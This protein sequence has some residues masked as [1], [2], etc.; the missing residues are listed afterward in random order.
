MKEK[1]AI[2]VDAGYITI[3]LHKVLGRRVDANTIH[4]YCNG[5]LNL[6]PL[7]GC[8]LFRIYYYDCP[9]IDDEFTDPNGKV[10]NFSKS[11]GTHYREKVR[12][13]LRQLSNV[14]IRTGELTFKG[15]IPDGKKN[16]DLF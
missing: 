10:I 1:V 14:V 4:R 5:L 8:Q 15:W 16:T 3:V 11:S 12:D 13:G 9:S 2:F 7:R 6:P